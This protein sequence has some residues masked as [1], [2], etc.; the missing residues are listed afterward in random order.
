MILEALLEGSE[1]G[2][3]V[4]VSTLMGALGV[5]GDQILI[6]VLLH[7]TEVLIP[8]LATFDSEV[9]I[10]ESAVEAFEEAIALGTSDFRFAV[11]DFL[12]LE[13]EFVGVV[14]RPPAE[15]ASVVR[16]DGLGF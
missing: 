8:L 6:E 5:V 4:H 13:E 1:R 11:F 9:L 10:K 14:I 3:P 12:D 16:E 15:L 7:F 2:S